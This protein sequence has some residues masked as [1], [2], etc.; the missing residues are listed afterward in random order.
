MLPF[1]TQ[2]QFPLT[3]A[4]SD[5]DVLSHDVDDVQK[6]VDEGISAY[7]A[8]LKVLDLP[9]DKLA[10]LL[11]VTP[12]AANFYLSTN[13]V[14]PHRANIRKMCNS[15]GIH[16]AYLQPALR[17]DS[18]YDG[19]HRTILDAICD[20]LADANASWEERALSQHALVSEE[21]KFEKFME[22]Y[23]ERARF[24]IDAM[25][26]VVV[27]E[28]NGSSNMRR[29]FNLL[30]LNK[31]INDVETCLL[32]YQIH[33]QDQQRK[34]S[35]AKDE[36]TKDA[37]Y[38]HQNLIDTLCTK[39]YGE[40]FAE[41]SLN[42]LTNNILAINGLKEP[43]P[44]NF[45]ASHKPDFLREFSLFGHAQGF[46]DAPIL[47]P[48][49]AEK[50]KREGEDPEKIKKMFSRILPEYIEKKRT[51]LNALRNSEE[52]D[53]E[54]KAFNAWLDDEETHSLDIPLYRNYCVARYH[55]PK[56]S[57]IKGIEYNTVLAR[58]WG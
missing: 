50:M 31:T 42:I 3:C 23:P 22:Q 38:K 54:L 58:H 17:L 51:Y 25:T 49:Y 12:E 33:L 34:A 19:Y 16:P 44:K 15:L 53:S 21:K 5:L 11:C 14:S 41:E 30:A 40:D 24:L 13:K 18:F 20:V 56:C 9:S 36:A 43:V 37:G 7:A 28:P 47:Q 32:A 2:T 35:L 4:D 27:D 46:L 1:N 52:K 48:D 8:W 10:D 57:N 55:L 26:Y 39:L 45:W 29:S 6:D